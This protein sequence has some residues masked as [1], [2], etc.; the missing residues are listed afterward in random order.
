[1]NISSISNSKDLTFQRK[2]I[3]VADANAMK[4]MAKA[5]LLTA[6]G[7]TSTVA[8]LGSADSVFGAGEVFVN[9]VFSPNVVKSAEERLLNHGE[10]GLP[11]QSTVLPSGLISTGG[12]CTKEGV[13]ELTNRKIPS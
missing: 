3:K 5:G 13:K 1:M 11:V 8:G 2:M 4:K 7:A 6:A 9:N 12:Y 10:Y